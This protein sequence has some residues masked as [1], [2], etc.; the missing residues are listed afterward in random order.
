MKT[1]TQDSSIISDCSI[2][3]IKGFLFNSYGEIN[4][5]VS[6]VFQGTVQKTKNSV[7][8]RNIKTLGIIE[9][10]LKWIVFSHAFYFN[11]DMPPNMYCKYEYYHTCVAF[12]L[13]PLAAMPLTINDSQLLTV[14][15]N[16]KDHYYH[17]EQ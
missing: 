13:E 7:C 10:I 3:A 15:M 1:S 16:I 11:N 5:N 17:S 2:I 12:T 9:S 6:H 8:K 4:G 14:C